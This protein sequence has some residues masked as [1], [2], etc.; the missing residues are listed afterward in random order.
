MS[1]L[2]IV[3]LVALLLAGCATPR[4]AASPTELMLAAPPDAALEA[5]AEALIA[6]GHVVRHADASLGRLEA[7]FSRWPGY[8]VLVRVEARG[9]GSQLAL[10]ATRGGRVLP[11]STL[12]RL[13]AEIAA[14]L[15]A[16][17]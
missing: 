3:L 12:E 10:T 6:G 14:R 11:P 8:R 16:S 7:V 5:A 1:R 9:E 13:T 15:A 4:P 17:D 2:P